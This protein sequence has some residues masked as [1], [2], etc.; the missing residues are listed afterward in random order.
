[1][2]TRRASDSGDLDQLLMAALDTA[3]ALAEIDDGP[4]TI[5]DHLHL[6]VPGIGNDLL[7]IDLLAAE[8][9]FGLG[10]AAIVDHFQLGDTGGHAHPSA[11]AAADG[12]DHD[13]AAGAERREEVARLFETL[14]DRRCPS[15]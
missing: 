8:R 15:G 10:P 6:D 14:W 4:V 3:F 7:D 9:R 12:L 13:P 1:M 11:A 2:R 5:A